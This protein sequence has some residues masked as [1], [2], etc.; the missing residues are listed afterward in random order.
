M[1]EIKQ[2]IRKRHWMSELFQDSNRV[3]WTY[4]EQPQFRFETKWEFELFLSL[5]IRTSNAYKKLKVHF[6]NFNIKRLISIPSPLQQYHFHIILIWWHSPFKSRNIKRFLKRKSKCRLHRMT[7]K[8]GK[9]WTV[10]KRQWGVPCHPTGLF[11]RS[12]WWSSQQTTFCLSFYNLLSIC[13][14]HDPVMLAM[15]EN[16]LISS[17]FSDRHQIS[18][19]AHFVHCPKNKF[20]KYKLFLLSVPKA[21]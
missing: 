14:R 13:I 3:I 1:R 17:S 11:I 6:K 4:L 12:I 21:C 15:C 19:S 5:S 7:P 8:T 2:P 10:D 9:D 16:F 20:R 18:A